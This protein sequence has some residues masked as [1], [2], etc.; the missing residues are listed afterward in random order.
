MTCRSSRV[1]T[2]LI[3]LWCRSIS[4]CMVPQD[5]QAGL[6]K[7]WLAETTS[8]ASCVA[9]DWAYYPAVFHRR[10]RNRTCHCHP[11]TRMIASC[12]YIVFRSILR[13]TLPCS[14]LTDTFSFPA[15]PF[16]F[17]FVLRCYRKG[18]PLRTF[19]LHLIHQG[20][21]DVLTVMSIQANRVVQAILTA[22]DHT[23]VVHSPHR[24]AS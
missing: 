14:W 13:R 18:H 5:P 2:V 7:Q 10:P 3:S 4:S 12:L 1:Q 11:G 24:P 22:R 19:K 6:C 20:I 8:I 17:P 23:A 21:P 15:R 16:S 9:I